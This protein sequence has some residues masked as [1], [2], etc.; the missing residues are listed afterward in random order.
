MINN[1]NYTIQQLISKR[2]SPN[3]IKYSSLMTYKEFDF[4]KKNSF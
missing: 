2:T 3:E 1:K 4:F